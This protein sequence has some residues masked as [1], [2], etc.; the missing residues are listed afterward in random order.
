MDAPPVIPIAA[1][2]FDQ[3][4]TSAPSGHKE[5]LTAYGSPRLSDRVCHLLRS[6]MGAARIVA[7]WLCC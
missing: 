4:A 2:N 5:L 6:D 7:F 3:K 1:F